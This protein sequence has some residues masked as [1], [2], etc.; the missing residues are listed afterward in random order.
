[1]NKQTRPNDTESIL[2]A[3][4]ALVPVIIESREEIERERRLPMRLVDALKEAGVF[5]MTTPLEWG[6]NRSDQPIAYR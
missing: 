6:R 3:A 1:M 5:R 4:K 2:A